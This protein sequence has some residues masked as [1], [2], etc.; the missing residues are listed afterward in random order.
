MHEQVRKLYNRYGLTIPDNSEDINR[1]AF[2]EETIPET[3]K[4]KVNNI[5]RKKVGHREYLF[6]SKTIIGKTI[7]N[8]PRNLEVTEGYYKAPIFVQDLTDNGQIVVTDKVQDWEDRY[9]IPYSPEKVREIIKKEH[10]FETEKI[11]LTLDLGYRKYTVPSLNDFIN[12]P[13]DRLARKL[14]PEY[15][16]YYDEF[17]QQQQ[18]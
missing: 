9:E 16:A 2:Y 13:F 1:A 10:Q 8:A 7:K 15:N 4:V 18:Q 5:M 11:G 14:D 6:V 17:E 12:L 3:R